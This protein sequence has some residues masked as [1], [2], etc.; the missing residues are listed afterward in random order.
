MSLL[1]LEPHLRQA[2][3]ASALWVPCAAPM[4]DALPT[5]KLVGRHGE[6]GL[7]MLPRIPGALL[8]VLLRRT[9]GHGA[10]LL[11]AFKPGKQEARQPYSWSMRQLCSP[12]TLR[13]RSG[14]RA[15]PAALPVG[16]YSYPAAWQQP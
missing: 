16:C 11:Y 2:A 12:C 14:T 8:I 9:T 6:R 15:K 7:L 10:G 1:H 13:C 3:L 4:P 5:S